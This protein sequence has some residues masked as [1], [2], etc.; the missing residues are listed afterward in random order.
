MVRVSLWQV[1]QGSVGVILAAWNTDIARTALFCMSLEI[2]A[3][4][5][6]PTSNV[7]E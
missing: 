6:R 4:E 7:L 1:S 5:I 2:G 3:L